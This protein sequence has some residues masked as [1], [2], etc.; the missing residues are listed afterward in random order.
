MNGLSWILL[1][2]AVVA[3]AVAIQAGSHLAVAVPA[4]AVAVLLVSIVGATELQSRSSPLTPV[5]GGV[6]RPEVP[7]RVEFDSLLRLRR[8]FRSGKIGRSAILATVHALERDLGTAGRTPLTVN[9][10][11]Q[12]LEMPLAQFRKWVDERLQRIEVAS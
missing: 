4:G 9:E 8:A 1:G 7:P 12:A 6:G 11:R 3:A 10:E 2:G 5:R